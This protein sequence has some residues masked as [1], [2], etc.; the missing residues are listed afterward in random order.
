MKNLVIGNPPLNV[1]WLVYAIWW[2]WWC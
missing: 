1:L 2:C